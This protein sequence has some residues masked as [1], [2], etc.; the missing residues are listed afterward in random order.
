MSI[1][2]FTLRSSVG[3]SN[4]PF[5]LGHTFKKGD[6][7][8]GSQLTGSIVN[9]QVV[10]KSTWPDGSLKFAIV[11]GLAP[12]TANTPLSVTLSIGTPTG[13][14]AII[15]GNGFL[16]NTTA[17][18]DAGIFGQ[19]TWTT[20]D[21]S[22][23]FLTW[24]SGPKMTSC[25]YRKSIGT[26]A[27]LVAW[28]EVRVYSG[29][30]IEVLPWLE[31]GYLQLPGSSISTTPTSKSATYVFTLG[32]VQRASVAINLPA[33][34]RTPIISGTAT[35]YWLGT[36]PQVVPRH[37]V[38]YMQ[39]TALVP[40]YSGVT[41]S[42]S[43]QSTYTPLQ[44]GGF[45]YGDDAMP[46]TG[47][48]APIG[49]LP[50]HDVLYLTSTDTGAYASVIRNG[51]SAGRY[52]IY[53]RDETTNRPLRFSSHPRASL[54]Y[55]GTGQYPVAATG[56]GAPG[57]DIPHHPSMGY[58][59]YLLTGHWYHMETV[60]FVATV[61]YLG[62][63]DQY[64]QNE[65]GIFL[66]ESGACTVRG[67][68]WATR[69]LLQAT[70]ATP[71]N[72]VLRAE[73][74]ASLTANIDFNHTT[75]VA[76]PHNPFGIVAPYGDGYGTPTDGKQQDAPWQQD[77]YTATYGYMLA[78]DPPITAPTKTKLSAF[79]AWK[80]QS[81]IGRL[82]GIGADEWLYRDAAP[83]NFTVA[84]VDSPDWGGGTGPWPASWG[85]LYQAT[86][87]YTNP[88]VAGDLR[89]GN[90]PATTSYWANLKPA[91]SYAVQHGVAG[92]DVAY[93]RMTG[94]SNYSAF[95]A[96]FDE[97]PVW[98]VEPL[99]TQ[100]TGEQ[101]VS[102]PGPSFIWDTQPLVSGFV[103]GTHRGHGITSNEVPTG[104][105]NAALLLNDID[106]GDPAGTEYR[107]Q[108]LTGTGQQ[109]LKINEDS[110]FSFTGAPDGQYTG[111]QRV[112]KNG[113]AAYDTTYSFTVGNVSTIVAADGRCAGVSSVGGVSKSIKLT[114]GSCQGRST[115]MG[116]AS[117]GLPGVSSKDKLDITLVAA[118][119]TVELI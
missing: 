110:S 103:W 81:A 6:V 82:G 28:L 43:L 51:F 61:N 57:W 99:T 108:I 66:S 113:V 68:A 18:I 1:A 36:D 26:D 101:Q 31:N 88:G 3:G 5:S 109:Y 54:N 32:G 98:S 102:T 46:S 44:Q 117:G 21:W 93:A 12:L 69:T 100:S 55:S 77:F 37:D 15:P 80:A 96:G 25:I 7:P 17:T 45:T 14:T 23:P 2:S 65:K 60:Q 87:G 50:T 116:F 52:P 48:S 115:V 89:G 56:T 39:E 33:R 91:I 114:R 49:L 90:Y 29:G 83:Y 79:F 107:L 24:V 9:L 111:T 27:H 4:L 16:Y 34:T 64:R 78:A 95:D 10:P 41:A 94:A 11:S 62:Q 20:T 84:L 76:Q 30:A 59:A 40:K 104:F 38:A 106:A 97:T 13:G 105:T 72:D 112:F 92:A 118:P 63:V 85:A 73:F 53:Y 35:S 58:M 70:T 71:D 67:A 42:P 47:F 86:Y 75:Y 119:Y 22:S 8:S 19:A 74:V